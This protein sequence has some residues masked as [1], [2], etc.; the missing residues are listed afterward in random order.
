MNEDKE[1]V[2][3]V[4]T[5]SGTFVTVTILRENMVSKWTVKVLG[6]V[7]VKGAIKAAV[8]EARKQA[9]AALAELAEAGVES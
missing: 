3:L 7:G 5:P 2:K 4:H 1:W 9:T 8:V 6:A